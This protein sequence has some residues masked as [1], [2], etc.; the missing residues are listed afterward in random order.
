M[1]RY[2]ITIEPKKSFDT[3]IVRFFEHRADAYVWGANFVQNWNEFTKKYPNMKY[4]N[5]YEYPIL[6]DLIDF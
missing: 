1:K 4:E 6:T 3:P 2:K 5:Y